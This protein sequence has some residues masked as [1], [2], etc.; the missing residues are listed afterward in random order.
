MQYL[1]LL[2]PLS[3]FIMVVLVVFIIFYL[4]FR[5]KREYQRTIQK[6]IDSGQGVSE[7]FIKQQ[8]FKTSVAGRFSRGVKLIAV[9]LALGI[10]LWLVFG[11]SRFYW[12]WSLLAI[13]LGLGE[14]IIAKILS[15]QHD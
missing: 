4:R 12:S 13:A 6:M 8:G 15:N 10:A 2:V 9:G 7:A 14:L 1:G 5:E 11:F 3:P